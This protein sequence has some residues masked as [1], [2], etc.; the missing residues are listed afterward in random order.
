MSE[1]KSKELAIEIFKFLAP[2]AELDTQTILA[3]VSMVLAA[4]AVEA[5]V[6]EEKAMYAFRKSYGKAER[7]LKQVLKD[8]H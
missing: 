4:I 1:D 7:R 3:A 2:K 8:I 6:E 5:G